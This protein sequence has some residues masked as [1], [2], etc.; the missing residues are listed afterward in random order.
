MRKRLVFSVLVLFAALPAAAERLTVERGSDLQSVINYAASGD[1]IVIAA[2][3]FSARPRLFTD[4]LCGN[5]LDPHTPVEASHGFIIRGKS[6]ELIGE[7]RT[8]SRL[9]TNAGYGLF[10]VDCPEVRIANLTIT[11]G[12]RDKDGNATDAGIVVRNSRVDISGV[13]I[14][15]NTHRL[16]SVVVGIG[17]VF[18]REGS[19]IEIRDCRIVDN[20]WDGVALYRGAAATVTDCVIRDGRGAGIGV[21]WDATCAAY[22]NDISGYWKG[23]GAF[24]TSWV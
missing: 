20:G 15:G 10:I 18:G 2:K 9:E 5:C 11:G 24:G 23:I 16:D 1:T 4:S 6:L 19:E 22:R 12:R 3:T 13:T 7:S 17:G 14:A 8:E 21:T